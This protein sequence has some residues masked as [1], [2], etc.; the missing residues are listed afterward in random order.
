MQT[1]SHLTFVSD[2]HF[3]SSGE[4][5]RKY[6]RFQALVDHVA[7]A[8]GALY[9]LG[10]LFDFGFPYRHT[11]PKPAVPVLGMLAELIRR[12]S[13]VFFL[14]GNHDH[15]MLPYLEQETD[16]QILPEGAVVEAQG[17]RLV[18]LHGDGL[19]PGDTGYKIL[20]KV[21][22]HPAAIAVFRQLHPD[23]G[24]AL[25]I[26]SSHVSRESS[27]EHPV[28]TD[29]LYRHVALPRLQAGADFVLMGHHHVLHREEHGEGTFVI[30]GDGFKQFT[31]AQLIDGLFTLGAW[32]GQDPAAAAD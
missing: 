19:G 18:L 17:K 30:L 8:G 28:D 32:P 16:I 5:P 25:G 1:R 29:L 7:E 2:I 22:R 6:A 4:N 24:V 23:A 21:L 27:T 15:W 9:I 12:G 20:K 3:G 31:C 11:V 26:R 13:P 14:G 10:D